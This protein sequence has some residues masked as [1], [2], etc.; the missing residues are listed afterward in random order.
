MWGW[1]VDSDTGNICS[2]LSLVYY[3]VFL[4][5]FCRYADTFSIIMDPQEFTNKQN[6]KEFCTFHGAWQS[7]PTGSDL[8]RS[9]AV[10]WPQPRRMHAVGPRLSHQPDRRDP[11]CTSLHRVF[12][13]R[14]HKSNGALRKCSS[15]SLMFLQ[16]QHLSELSHEAQHNKPA[17]AKTSSKHKP[18]KITHTFAFIT[19]KSRTT[20]VSRSG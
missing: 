5:T 15:L 8:L 2:Y 18:R 16:W 1:T 3:N 20:L 10:Q 4:R 6:A 11:K 19:F 7:I 12:S 17:Y 13:Q 14:H 9:M